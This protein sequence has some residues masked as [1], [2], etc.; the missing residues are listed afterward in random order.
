MNELTIKPSELIVEGLMD[1]C[2][3]LCVNDEDL[4]VFESFELLSQS[5]PLLEYGYTEDTV[6]GVVGL[7]I[8]FRKL[9]ESKS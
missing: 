1:E 5:L 9:D 3:T 6:R 7:R 2:D 8:S 4:F